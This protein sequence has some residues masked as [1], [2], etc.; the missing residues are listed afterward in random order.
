LKTQVV[1]YSTCSVHR[2]ENEDVVEAVLAEHCGDFQLEN[3]MPEW[4]HRGFKSGR[5]EGKHWTP[6]ST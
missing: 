2:E 1:V 5:F 3:C 4:P 6:L